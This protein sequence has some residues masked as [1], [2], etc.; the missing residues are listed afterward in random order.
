MRWILLFALSS[1]LVAQ[2][3]APPARKRLLIIGEEKG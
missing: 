2:P 3:T 1:V